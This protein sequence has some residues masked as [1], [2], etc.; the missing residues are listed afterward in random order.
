[1]EATATDSDLDGYLDWTTARYSPNYVATGD[2]ETAASGDAT[3]PAGWLRSGSTSATA[4]RT[5]AAGNF[6]SGGACSSVTWGLQLVTSGATLQRLYQVL[7]AYEP[8]RQH[9][10]TFTA[11]SG[12]SVHGRAFVYDRTTNTML[13]NVEVTSSAWVTYTVPFTMPVAGHVVE[14]WL[15]PTATA[16]AAQAIYYD[17]VRISAYY[18]Y[19]VLDGMIGIPVARFVRLVDQNPTALAAYA[20]KATSYRTFLETQVIAKWQDPGAFYGNTWVHAPPDRSRPAPLKIEFPTSR[21]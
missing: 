14:V 3:L 12:G 21:T 20:T 1:V 19:H 6:I 15:A 11:K 8:G 2:F 17:N 10:L 5:N 18:S 9:Q 7:G 16:P 4:F 13:A